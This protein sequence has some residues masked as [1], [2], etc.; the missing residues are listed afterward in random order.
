MEFNQRHANL[1]PHTDAVPAT[2]FYSD[3]SAAAKRKKVPRL[4]CVDSPLVDELLQ[5]LSSIEAFEEK[6]GRPM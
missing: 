6:T 1:F 3:P 4:L 5:L 2:G